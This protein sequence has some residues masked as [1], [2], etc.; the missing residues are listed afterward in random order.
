MVYLNG[1]KIGHFRIR[2]INPVQRV[3]SNVWPIKIF[4]SK[5]ESCSI[6]CFFNSVI[7]DLALIFWNIW[8]CKDIFLQYTSGDFKKCQNFIDMANLSM[9][10]L[11][12][13]LT[14][15]FSLLSIW[16][17][18]LGDFY[19]E[20]LGNN[21]DSHQICLIIIYFLIISYSIMTNN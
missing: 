10:K 9:K 19:K 20:V 3:Y 8:D 7:Y 13:K 14:L 16:C 11:P 4:L 1:N 15:V 17:Y 18:I 12:S 5:K 21:Y 6:G 2:Q